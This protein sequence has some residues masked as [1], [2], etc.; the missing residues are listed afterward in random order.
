M[1][2]DCRTA[3]T[4]SDLEKLRNSGS[5][6][7]KAA[8]Q[9][10]LLNLVNSNHMPSL[11]QPMTRKR[12]SSLLDHERKRETASLVTTSTASS[13][14]QTECI[15]PR[16]QRLCMTNA[17][18]LH[19]RPH[20]MV[21]R[22][23]RPSIHACAAPFGADWGEQLQNGLYKTVSVPWPILLM[24]RAFACRRDPSSA[25]ASSSKKKLT[26]LAL[27]RKYWSVFFVC[28]II[29]VSKFTLT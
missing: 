27:A 22:C 12:E 23:S 25:N 20:S 6:S 13:S 19:T 29:L 9:Q 24:D 5:R 10:T 8:G 2:R 18:C 11:P 17:D 21:L 15:L 28:M 16:K 4:F 26:L 1:F 7:C 14:L 3:A